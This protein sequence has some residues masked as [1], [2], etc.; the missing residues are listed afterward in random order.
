MSPDEN[1]EEKRKLWDRALDRFHTQLLVGENLA[2]TTVESYLS[3]LRDFSDFCLEQGIRNPRDV[4]S[5]LI[6]DYLGARKKSGLASTSLSRRISTFKRFYRYLKGEGE[7]ESNPVQK[8]DHPR[9]YDSFPDYL[10]PKEGQRLLDQPDTDTDT[11]LGVR[12]RAVLELL[13]G[14]GLRVSELTNLPAG[15]VHW[16]SNELRVRGKGDKERVVPMGRESQ[17]W[18]KDYARDV[19]SELAEKGTSEEFFLGRNGQSLS[20]GRVYQL[21]RKYALEADLNDVSPHTL[22]HSFATHLLKNGAD[23]R[24]IQKMLGHADL[25]TTADIYLHLKDELREAHEKYHP[26][27]Q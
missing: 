26:R 8:L 12:D 4:D 24:S 14:S 27:G 6:T 3:D 13:Y 1:S 20:R 5:F 9:N 21:V 19:R 10:D 15:N 2:E 22:R 7:V 18:M 23:V 17:K 25:G 11:D 16:E